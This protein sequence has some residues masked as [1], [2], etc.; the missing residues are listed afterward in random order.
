MRPFSDSRMDGS[1]IKTPST[2]RNSSRESSGAWGVGADGRNRLRAPRSE[3]VAGDSPRLNLARTSRAVP[4]EIPASLAT[5]RRLAPGRSANSWAAVFLPSVVLSGRTRPS[6][7]TRTFA[8][9]SPSVLLRSSLTR[10]ADIPI[11]S[12]IVRSDQSG[13]SARIRPAAPIRSSCD[14]GNPCFAFNL[15]ACTKASR[16]VPSNN[17]ISISSSPRRIAARTRCSPS[18]TRIVARCTVIGGSRSSDSANNLTCSTS[19]PID[20]NEYP[21]S[22]SDILTCLHS[23]MAGLVSPTSLLTCEYTGRAASPIT[24]YYKPLWGDSL[25]SQR[26]TNKQDS[27][28]GLLTLCVHHYLRM[29]GFQWIERAPWPEI[30]RH[31]DV[32]PAER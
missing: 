7:P 30:A 15:T 9:S 21:R 18:M 31:P 14:S 32:F 27:V 16:S 22:K 3:G 1:R 13:N 24:P 2:F 12:A 23:R 4:A 29:G 6:L 26:E 25:Q 10:F 5:S 20:R 8:S 19:I 11:S 28:T 17:S